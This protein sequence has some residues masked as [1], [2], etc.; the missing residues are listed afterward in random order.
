MQT[1]ERADVSRLVAA[2]WRPPTPITVKA[3]DGKTDL[4]GLMFTPSNLDSTRKYPV[5]NYVY[6]APSGSVGS[7]AFAAASRDHQ[8]LAELGF[9]VVVVDGLG[10]TGRSREFLD[11]SYGDISDNTIPDQIAAIKQL[12]QRHRFVDAEKVGIWGH[13]G[14][15]FATATAMFRYPDFYDVGVSQ[16]GNH[17]NR[18]YED[19]WGERYQGLQ[20]KNG[21]S[22]NYAAHANQTYAKDLK[23]KLFLIHGAMDDNV[24]ITNTYLVADALVK[25]NKDF[26]LLVLPNARHGFGADNN[27]VMR[28]RWDYF[29]THLR[30]EQPPKEYQI[31]RPPVVP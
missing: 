30:G 19:D 1:V 7:R 2:G 31:G 9:V 14:G 4:Y 18:N 5:V 26:D 22:D 27:Y 29:V 11:V 25:A 3:R 17:D 8:A 20:Q 21:G 24:P 6:P 15:G 28:R 16:A 13:S 23:G 10:T 12:A